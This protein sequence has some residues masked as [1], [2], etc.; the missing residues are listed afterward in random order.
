PGIA[1]LPETG[2]VLGIDVGFSETRHSSAVC[3]L[4]WDLTSVGWQI[5][6]FRARDDERRE[7]IRRCVGGAALLSVAIDGPLKSGF[8]VIGKYR[9]AERMLTRRLRPYIGKPGQASAPVGQELNRYAN[10]C[11]R[12]VLEIC[13]VN[14][15]QHKVAIHERAVVE[16]FP[17]SYLGL[18][19]DNPRLLQAVKANR[20]DMFFVGLMTKQTLEDFTHQLA[21]RRQPQD[22]WTITNHDDRAAFVCALTAL[23]IAANDFTA[24]GDEDGWIILPPDSLIAPW[25]RPLLSENDSDDETGRFVSSLAA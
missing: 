10:L 17:S 13:A 19:L 5:C 6:R 15:S 24:V 3:R 9:A 21:P 14:S 25:A 12:D 11:A 7:A 1:I 20:S 22:L 8:P 2:S 18:L 23:S 4:S 16:A